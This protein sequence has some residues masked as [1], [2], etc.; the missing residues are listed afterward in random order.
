MVALAIAAHPDDIEFG[1]AGTLLLLKDRGVSIHMWNLADGSCGS[2]ELNAAEI[3]R[4][5]L[6]EAGASARVAGAAFYPPIARDLAIFYE[7]ALLRQ[8]AAKIREIRSGILLVPSLQ[9]YMEDHVNTARLAVTAAFSR[10]M[11][12][13][14]TNPPHAPWFGEV[15]IYHAMPHGGRDSYGN[16]VMPERFVDIGTTMEQKT[17]MLACHESQRGWLQDSQAIDSYL[18]AM[19]GDGERLGQMSRKYQYAEGWCKHNYLGFA[20]NPDSDPLSDLLGPACLILPGK[21][22]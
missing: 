15:T 6:A 16:F 2:T 22:I 14:Q 13:Y 8:V 12:N 1:M 3:A 17:K 9:D 5:R 20:T 10:G 7:D 18:Q 21:E 19:I 4:V 11:P